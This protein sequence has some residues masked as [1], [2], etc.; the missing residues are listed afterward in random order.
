MYHIVSILPVEFV[1]DKE[2]VKDVSLYKITYVTSERFPIPPVLITCD[3]PNFF[4]I[5]SLN[6]NHMGFLFYP[7]IGRR[8]QV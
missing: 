5:F 1:G 8:I 7:V 4:L 3:M 6:N 2:K